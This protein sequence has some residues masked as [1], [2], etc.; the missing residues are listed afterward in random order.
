VNSSWSVISAD[1]SFSS[2]YTSDSC[3]ICPILWAEVGKG[4]KKILISLE[5]VDTKGRAYRPWNSAKL[6]FAEGPR[7]WIRLT[8]RNHLV[9]GEVR[10]G[11]LTTLK[12]RKRRKMDKVYFFIQAVA[13][14]GNEIDSRMTGLPR[15]GGGVFPSLFLFFFP[16]KFKQAWST[17]DDRTRNRNRFP[18]WADSGQW[19]KVCKGSRQNRKVT[20]GDFLAEVESG[21]LH[22]HLPSKLQ[23]T[24]TNGI[25]LFN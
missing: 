5:W 16:W 7:K 9:I 23:L 10:K 4:F 3:Y 21:W 12:D 6:A 2:N 19:W 13:L 11:D 20:L 15:V 25:R 8:L 24:L 14:S 17:R 1:L 18:S 22:G